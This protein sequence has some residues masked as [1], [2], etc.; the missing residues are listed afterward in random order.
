MIIILRIIVTLFL[1]TYIAFEGYYINY[2]LDMVYEVVEFLS[3][4]CLIVGYLKEESK[5]MLPYMAVEV[6][7]IGQIILICL[8]KIFQFTWLLI[9]LI[10]YIISLS[11]LLYP[12]HFYSW[13]TD[14]DDPTP[15]G[16]KSSAFQ[17]AIRTLIYSLL[18]GI[19]LSVLLA[20]SRYFD[21]EK[22]RLTGNRERPIILNVND[23]PAN[24]TVVLMDDVNDP[25]EDSK[26]AKS[27]SRESNRGFPNPNFTLDND[28]EDEV[29]END[30]HRKGKKTNVLQ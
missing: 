8:I 1:F 7:N 22:E 10:I 9:T 28:S 17:T 26:T 21:D 24:N 29:D 23:E 12:K 5:W 15:E 19:E 6:S 4:I 3:L 25:Q 16:S 13:L 20:C 27:N 11:A 14:P 2:W 30:W 18:L